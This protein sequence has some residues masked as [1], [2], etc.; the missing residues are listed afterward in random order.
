MAP[1]SPRATAQIIPLPTAAAAPVVNGRIPGRWPACVVPAYR[2]VSKRKARNNPNNQVQ[3]NAF[4]DHLAELQAA[5]RLHN[6]RPCNDAMTESEKAEQARLESFFV[7]GYVQA[8]RH[9]RKGGD[10]V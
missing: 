10:H 4:L 6:L 1:A 9:F 2:L 5:A 7:R 8:D 3:N